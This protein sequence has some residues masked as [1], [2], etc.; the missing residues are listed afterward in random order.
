[1]HVLMISLDNS[2]LGDPHGNTVQRHIEYARRIGDLSVVVYNPSSQ[3]GRVT[4]LSDHLVVYPANVPTPL[5]FSL[6]AFRVAARIHRER[7]AEVVT[8]QDPFSTGL[9][10]LGLKWRFGT[11][12][13]AQ[14]HSS[15]F[16]N[17]DWIR[18][19]PLRNR[20]FHILGRFVV[21]RADTN[22]V[23]TEGEKRHYLAMGIPAE[24]VTVLPTP[25]HVDMFAAPV[26]EA[27]LAAVRARLDLTPENPVALWV[28][29]PGP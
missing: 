5:L 20:A 17:Q 3:A 19:R 12:F 18:E 24:R 9:V 8:T 7:P 2:L 27:D 29:L 15:F 22:R 4:R 16:N 14:N 26:P 11:P 13:D 25:T 6:A 10:G 23:L 21:R 28:G 1:M